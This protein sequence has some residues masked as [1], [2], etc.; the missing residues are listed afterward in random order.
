M[1]KQFFYEHDNKQFL[2]LWFIQELLK[3]KLIV[4]APRGGLVIGPSH[5]EGGIVMFKASNEFENEFEVVAEIEGWEFLANPFA[6]A[7]YMEEFVN[8]NQ[9]MDGTLPFTPY[10]IPEDILILDA[11]PVMVAGVKVKKWILLGPK[12]QYVVNRHSTQK[13]LTW[14][15]ETNETTWFENVGS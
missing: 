11:M 3:Y 6:T 13:H 14:L 15:H 4:E 8:I 2:E 10:E 9:E 12:G 1:Q 7:Q 5:D